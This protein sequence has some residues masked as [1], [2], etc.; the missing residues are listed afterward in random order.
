MRYLRCHLIPIIVSSLLNTL[1]ILITDKKK[2]QLSNTSAQFLEMQ[3]VREDGGPAVL[4][5]GVQW[6]AALQVSL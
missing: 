3:G 6:E 2:A 1:S 4:G 5:E